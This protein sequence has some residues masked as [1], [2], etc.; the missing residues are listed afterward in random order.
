MALFPTYSTFHLQL[1]CLLF[2]PEGNSFTETQAAYKRTVDGFGPDDFNSLKRTTYQ[3]L[4]RMS[5]MELI[6]FLRLSAYDSMLFQKILPR[7]KQA[8]QRI[9]MNERTRLAETM[10]QTWN[11]YFTI[12][13]AFDLAYEMGGLFYDLGYYQEALDYFGYSVN[14]YGQ[15]ADVFYNQALC[16]Y[17]LRQDAEFLE[18]FK[19]IKVFF[20][21]Y[22][23]LAHLE[24]LDL[25]A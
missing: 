6:A 9:S 23:G 13:G 8:A 7:I 19:Q 2:L 20:P 10:H 21:D 14:E 3:N 1:G 15:K 18:V 11:M 24:R 5:M 16:H 22:A 12:N 4:G 25:G 17:Q